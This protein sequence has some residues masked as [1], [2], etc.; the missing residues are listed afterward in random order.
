MSSQVSRSAAHD[1]R[2]KALR[3]G[4][5]SPAAAIEGSLPTATTIG[6]RAK[7]L[8]LDREVE[9]VPNSDGA[10]V[11]WLGDHT[12]IKVWV[13]LHGQPL[14]YTTKGFVFAQILI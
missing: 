10:R 7:D 1:E 3:A 8:K 9:D 11:H 5:S 13:Y 12:A 6:A 2:N 4:F 14:M